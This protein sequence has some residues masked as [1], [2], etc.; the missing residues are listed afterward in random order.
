VSEHWF[1]VRAI[2]VVGETVGLES[3]EARHA[4]GARRLRDGDAV[5]VFDGAGTIGR[6]RLAERGSAVVVESIERVEPASFR[7]EIAAAIPKGDRAATMLDMATQLGMT[8][9]IPLSATHSVVEGGDKALRRWQRVCVEACKQSRR[10]WLPNLRADGV[11]PAVAVAE[12]ITAGMA[13]LVA[14]RAGGCVD[15][16]LQGS[17]A[18]KGARVF[19]GPEGGFTP[20]EL[21]SIRDAG[22]VPVR[23]AEH[24]LRIETAAVAACALLQRRPR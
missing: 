8:A 16:V 4:G 10:A 13:A 5:T 12:S 7:L 19:I 20:S 3:D 18:A 17:S 14:D 6:G 11:E 1:L 21:D 9:F 2:E 23:L 24:I 15:E 22:A